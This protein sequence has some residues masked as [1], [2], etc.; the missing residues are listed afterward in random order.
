[1]KDIIEYLKKNPKI[2]EQLR[3]NQICL[4]GVTPDENK[5]ILDVV[6]KDKTYVQKYLWK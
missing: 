3:N 5:A 1:M 2:L 6:Q 4:I